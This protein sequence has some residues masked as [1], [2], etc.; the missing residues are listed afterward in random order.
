MRFYLSIIMILLGWVIVCGQ[1]TRLRGNV[2]KA[3]TG[4]VQT[5]TDRTLMPEWYG[6]KGD[7]KTDDT[8]AI[9]RCIDLLYEGKE[10]Q[11]EVL[12]SG[13]EYC[14]RN[15][16]LKGWVNLRGSGMVIISVIWYRLYRC[17]GTA[18]S[19]CRIFHIG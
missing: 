6:A 2:K 13:K 14:V 19:R 16:M 1:N 9:Q 18:N 11:G 15:I 12:L 7:G 8:E 4:I 3:N 5:M 17:F 10:K